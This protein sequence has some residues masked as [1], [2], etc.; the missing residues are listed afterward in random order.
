MDFKKGKEER[1]RRGGEKGRGKKK[2]KKGKERSQEGRRGRKKERGRKRKEGRKKKKERGRKRNMGWGEGRS[3]A[4][5]SQSLIP[6]LPPTSGSHE[7]ASCPYGFAILDILYKQNH[8]RCYFLCVCF[9]LPNIMFTRFTYIVACIST[10]F[11]FTAKYSMTWIYH[12]LFTH[13]SIDGYSGWF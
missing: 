11:L 1:K 6:L 3:S 5:S 12:I 2:E 4:L 8:T 10:S 13:S 9:L 7:S